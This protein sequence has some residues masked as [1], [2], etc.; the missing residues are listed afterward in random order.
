MYKKISHKLRNYEK[1][2]KNITKHSKKKDKVPEYCYLDE[3]EKTE[4]IEKTK[5]SNRGR[6]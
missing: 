3:S 5:I 1:L 4:K 2:K 6:G